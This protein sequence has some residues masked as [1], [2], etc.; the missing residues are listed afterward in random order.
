MV[1]FQRYGGQYF[2]FSRVK[3]H[4]QSTV[5]ATCIPAQSII[6][7]HL[8]AV[9]FNAQQ[10]RMLSLRFED[11]I[12]AQCLPF[13]QSVAT[14]FRLRHV[15]RISIHSMAPLLIWLHCA[16]GVTP[17]PPPPPPP[18]PAVILFLSP[19]KWLICPECELFVN[20]DFTWFFSRGP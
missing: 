17:I 7:V 3:F 2:L 16:C 18:P 4:H 12:R 10:R 14:V 20:Q 1:L 13:R 15:Q 9:R 6:I 19:W 5:P 8:H 11:P